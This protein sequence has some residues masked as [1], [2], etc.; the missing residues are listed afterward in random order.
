MFLGLQRG[1]AATP[2]RWSWSIPTI[3][4]V[5]QCLL[6]FLSPVALL[7]TFSVVGLFPRVS[8]SGKIQGT[9]FQVL[10]DPNHALF[11]AQGNRIDYVNKKSGFLNQNYACY[12]MLGTNSTLKSVHVGRFHLMLMEIGTR[13]LQCLTLEV[14]FWRFS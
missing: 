13:S 4:K 8:Q 2:S 9:L 12:V 3:V 6:T 11:V 10:V 1:A 7:G 5:N 14:H